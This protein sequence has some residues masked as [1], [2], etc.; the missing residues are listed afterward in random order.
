MT[1]SKFEIGITYEMR[2]IGDYNLRPHFICIKRTDKQV[3]LKGTHEIIRKKI[4]ISMDG[5]EYVSAGSYSMSPTIY[6][7]DIAK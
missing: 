1:T 3:T 6:S 5:D 2:F 4:A 7:K